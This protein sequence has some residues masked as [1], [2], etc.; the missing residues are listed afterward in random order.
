MGVSR[1]GEGRSLVGRWGGCGGK[2]EAGE[3]RTK[4]PK[5]AVGECW[6][7]RGEG[8]GWGRGDGEWASGGK[9]KTRQ[10]GHLMAL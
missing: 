7:G 2:E 9:E 4:K 1:E 3:R 5:R 8:I 6:M 10:G